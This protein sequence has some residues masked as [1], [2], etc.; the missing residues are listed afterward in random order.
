MMRVMC[1][2]GYASGGGRPK[3][4]NKAR[5]SSANDQGLLEGFVPRLL[6][7]LVPGGSYQR[8]MALKD[9]PAFQYVVP[10]ALVWPMHRDPPYTHVPCRAAV[11]CQVPH[12]TR[13]CP[14]LCHVH[15]PRP[16][17]PGRLQRHRPCPAR[18]RRAIGCDGC[19]TSA[20]A[21]TRHT[22]THTGGGGAGRHQG[23]P[24]GRGGVQ[25]RRAV[26][27]AQGGAP[28]GTGPRGG[29]AGVHGQGNAAQ[30]YDRR[31]ARAREGCTRIPA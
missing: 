30:Y 7:P 11:P 16:R 20:R 18:S 2:R 26:A 28:R 14:V 21:G 1:V 19:G 5:S 31:T 25:D 8:Y 15:R 12:H 17:D 22:A 13:V 24:A 6:L 23:V 10:C 29:A 3:G 9:D 4:G 27:G